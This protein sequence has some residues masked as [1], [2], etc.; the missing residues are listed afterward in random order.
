MRRK[1]LCSVGAL[2]LAALLSLSGC[3]FSS[4][5]RPPDPK[6]EVVESSSL[7]NLEVA[8]VINDGRMLHLVA[9]VL[10]PPSGILSPEQ[11]SLSSPEEY[12]L[13]L[14][15]FGSKGLVREHVQPLAEALIPDGRGSRD[16]IV[17]DVSTDLS[18]SAR[19]YLA[20]PAEGLTSYQLELL[21]GAEARGALKALPAPRDSASS[22][23]ALKD[24]LR[25]EGAQFEEPDASC[26][27]AGC[28][29][30]APLR[31]VLVNVGP[32]PIKGVDARISFSPADC[33]GGS[34]TSG[35]DTA[36]VTPITYPVALKPLK[37]RAG[38]R[39]VIKLRV[40][41]QVLQGIGLPWKCAPQA[42]LEVASVEFDSP[43]S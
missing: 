7:T 26:S 28:P 18:R 2:G 19:V 20:L 27:H 22:G 16:I 39:R 10:L 4:A 42:A 37:V 35:A 21:W 11:K 24:T 1:L 43:V 29:G 23:L 40:P 5:V 30:G 17:S 12:A 38:E 31:V 33:P 9:N 25:F 32:A 8:E 3:S 36:A 34:H 15:G 41:L 6:V 13:R 14:S